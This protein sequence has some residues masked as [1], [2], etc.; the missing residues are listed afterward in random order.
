MGA[1]GSTAGGEPVFVTARSA[2]ADAAAGATRAVRTR[3]SVSARYLPTSPTVRAPARCR[4]FWS[5][6]ARWR[7]CDLRGT[8]GE[9]AFERSDGSARSDSPPMRPM[10]ENITQRASVRTGVRGIRRGT[11][12]LLVMLGAVGAAAS[13]AAAAP[14]TVCASGCDATTIQGGVNAAT[15]GDTVEVGAGTYPEDVTVNKTLTLHGAGAG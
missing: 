6:D 9:G 14:V 2:S 8:V 1:P 3:T 10:I 4:H 7:R 13:S 15:P 11:V 12:C 5:A